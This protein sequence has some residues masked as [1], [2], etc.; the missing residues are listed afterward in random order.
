MR[1]IKK[2]SKTENKDTTKLNNILAIP[3][4]YLATLRAAKCLVA[5]LKGIV[6]LTPGVKRKIIFVLTNVVPQV[7]IRS[8]G[9]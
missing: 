9:Q 1:H 2:K 3:F 5:V 6:K 4:Y 7:K 8:F